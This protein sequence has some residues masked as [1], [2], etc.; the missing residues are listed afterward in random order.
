[1]STWFDVNLESDVWDDLREGR[2]EDGRHVVDTDDN[3]VS[4]YVD[5]V[6]GAGSNHGLIDAD[7]HEVEDVVR[8][9]AKNIIIKGNPK[10]AMTICVVCYHFPD[11]GFRCFW[12]PCPVTA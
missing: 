10:P 1:M 6:D 3:G 9:S 4:L 7:G 8:M 5:V 2:L 12:Y 11:G